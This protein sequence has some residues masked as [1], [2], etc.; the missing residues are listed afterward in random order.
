MSETNEHKRVKKGMP[1]EEMDSTI[2]EYIENLNPNEY[3]TARKISKILRIGYNSTLFRIAV[4]I[5][6]KKI[7]FSKVNKT[8][9]LV[10]PLK[11]KAI[12]VINNSPKKP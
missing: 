5:A 11:Y 4:L 7:N 8:L 12:S 2:L 1:Y 10:F 3:V 6:Q 9:T